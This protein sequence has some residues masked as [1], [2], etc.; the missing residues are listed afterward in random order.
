VRL[1]AVVALIA[2]EHT[3]LDGQGVNARGRSDCSDEWAAASHVSIGLYPP[4]PQ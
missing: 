4:K 3:I 1:R 2:Q